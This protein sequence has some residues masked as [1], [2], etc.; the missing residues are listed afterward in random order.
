MRHG[1]ATVTYHDG[2]VYIGMYEKDVKHGQGTLT[3]PDGSKYVG[4]FVKNNPCGEGSFKDKFGETHTGNF[5]YNMESKRLTMT[6]EQTTTDFDLPLG[7]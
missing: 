1:L 3:F 7:I 4:D 2:K 5:K 6:N